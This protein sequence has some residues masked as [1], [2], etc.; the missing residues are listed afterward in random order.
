MQILFFSHYFPPEGNAPASRTYEN[1]KRWVQ[2]GHLVVVITCAPNCPEGRVYEG[3]K[4]K[5]WKRENIDGI[6]VLRVWTYIA[7]NKGTVKRIANYVSY[8]FS[9]V[10]FNLFMKRPDIMIATSPQ[11]FCGWAGLIASKL[12]HTPFI[13]EIRDIWPESIVAVGAM[14]GKRL[15][16]W[17]ELLEEK[18][19]AWSRHIVTVGAG[20]SERLI[21][22]GVSPEK[23]S[24]VMNGVDRELFFP[25]E[26]D[27]ALREKLGLDGKFICSYIGTIGMA[28]GLDVVLR[29]GE[30]LKQKG[31]NDIVFLLVGDGAVREELEKVARRLGLDNV[32]FTGRKDKKLVPNFL[33][34]TDACLVHLKKTDLFTTVMPTKIFEAA[35]MARPIIIGVAGFAAQVVEDARAGIPIEPE[36]EKELVATVEKLADNPELCRSYGQSGNVY[37]MEHYDR[38]NLAMDYLHVLH[39]VIEGKK[40]V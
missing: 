37:I 36:N 15:L 8:L 32:I 1:C 26:P 18:M 6:E 28:C 34:I 14:Q 31:R 13:L 40:R 25:R 38:D 16:Q 30:I 10:F 11:F 12:R 4:N 39:R 20:Y 33:S 17:L 27:H 35:G 9:A 2:D 21:E 23:I 5:L 29:S 22:K 24:I 3:Y 19:Y 7:A